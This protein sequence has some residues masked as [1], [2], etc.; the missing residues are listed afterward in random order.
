[1]LDW[2]NVYT[3]GANQPH[4]VKVPITDTVSGEAMLA[5]DHQNIIGT[6]CDRF[7]RDGASFDGD[8]FRL[9][10]WATVVRELKNF[11]G[12]ITSAMAFADWNHNAIYEADLAQSGVELVHAPD[13]P[14]KNVDFKMTAVTVARAL[15]N[16]RTKRV[17]LLTHDGDFAHL[18]DALRA[19]GRS[20]ICVGIREMAISRDLFNVCD[21][22]YKISP[23][24]PVRRRFSC[25]YA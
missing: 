18:A 11:F 25:L 5:I 23:T 16:P 8:Q 7:Y 3:G 13:F 6:Q 24:L 22:V 15:R 9:I 4:A 12:P 1:M 10:D 2:K 20:V 21:A 17:I 14:H 19:S